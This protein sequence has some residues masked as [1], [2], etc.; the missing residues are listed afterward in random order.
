MIVS[1]AL[2]QSGNGLKFG[3]F[4]ANFAGHVLGTMSIEFHR[5]PMYLC[6]DL[7]FFTVQAKTPGKC[8]SSAN[9][10]GGVP[11]DHCRFFLSL[12][13]VN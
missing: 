3:D 12:S 13:A 4:L 5:Q 2:T 10:V 9:L 7:F 11:R 6:K 8:G 1:S